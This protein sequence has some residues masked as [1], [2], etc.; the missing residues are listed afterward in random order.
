MRKN[1]RKR[2]TKRKNTRK[3]G[4]QFQGGVRAPVGLRQRLESLRP[5]RPRRPRRSRRPRRPRRNR[6]PITDP[7]I[8]VAIREERLRHNQ[9]ENYRQDNILVPG[10][11]ALAVQRWEAERVERDAE[12]GGRQRPPPRRQPRPPPGQP[13]SRSE[14]QFDDS[15]L[16]VS[17]DMDPTDSDDSLIG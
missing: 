7:D 12:R 16:N 15:D 6:P 10:E 5:V 8:T 4:H 9:E 11:D 13:P 17:F 1:T 3:R 14:S 2:K